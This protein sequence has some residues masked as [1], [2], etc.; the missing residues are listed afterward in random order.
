L[1]NKYALVMKYLFTFLVITFAFFNVYAEVNYSDQKYD[2]N[3]CELFA[4][5][6]E[7]ASI[8]FQRGV[9]LQT[10]LKTIEHAPLTD[11]QKERVFQAVQFVYGNEIDNPVLAY[12][13]AM[14]L[15]LQPRYYMSPQDDPWH[16]NPRM[17]KN[18]L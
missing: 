15:C 5:D 14:G 16:T 2:P 7:K 9:T 3:A 11:S 10:I 13:L 8:N 1:G 6:A 12:Q 17:N 18:P 4:H